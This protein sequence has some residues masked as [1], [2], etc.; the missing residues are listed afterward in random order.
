MGRT[1]T[2][3][4]GHHGAFDAEAALFWILAGIIMLIAFGDALT[5]LA[6]AFAIVAAISWII[7]KVERR[8]DRSDSAL[9]SVTRLR[10]ELMGQAE[11]DRPSRVA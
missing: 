9:A 6:A 4:S 10:P 7:R 2:T 3:I 5:V 11:F 1:K 8:S